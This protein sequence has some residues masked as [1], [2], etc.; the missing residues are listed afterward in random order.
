MGSDIVLVAMTVVLF[1]MWGLPNLRVFFILLFPRK[2]RSAFEGDADAIQPDD[3]PEK[4]QE[5]LSSLAALGFQPLGIKS[6]QQPLLRVQELSYASAEDRTFA[7]VC[8]YEGE[9]PHY[10]LYTPFQDGAVVLTTTQAMEPVRTDTFV[11]H[12]VTQKSPAE[13]LEQH[14]KQVEKM[15]KKG[16]EPYNDFGRAARLKA[17]DAY[18]ANPGAAQLQNQLF[19]KSMRNAGTSLGLVLLAVLMLVYRIMKG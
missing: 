3:Y 16:H 10:Y 4:T 18:Y 1:L 11:H 13:V 5:L 6:E 8:R 14:R 12:G 9:H 2:I 17:T 7:A 19:H 15:S